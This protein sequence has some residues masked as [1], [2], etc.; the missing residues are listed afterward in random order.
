MNSK[1]QAERHSGFITKTYGKQN[2][3]NKKQN[4][5]KK[6]KPIVGGGGSIFGR[7]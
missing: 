6:N 1:P 7:L 2:I 3:P 4:Q 5:I